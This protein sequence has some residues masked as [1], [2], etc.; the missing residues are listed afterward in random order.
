MRI[1]PLALALALASPLALGCKGG[2]GGESA[3]DSTTSGADTSTSAGDTES[4][5]DLPSCGDG[6]SICITPLRSV[7]V[8]FVIDNS[9]S[10]AEEQALLAANFASFIEILESPKV[11]ADYRIG[12]TTTD[13]G[14]PMCPGSATTPEGGQLVLSSCV[15]RIPLGEFV[16]TGTDPVTDA[17]FACTESCSKGDAELAIQPSFTSADGVEK[18][19]P[20]IERIA[21][22]TNLPAGVSMTEA[23]QCF[24]PQ[25]VA[26]CGFESPLESLDRAL[27]RM[28]SGGEASYGFLRD[29]ALLAVIFLTDEV[30]CSYNPAHSEIFTDNKVFWNDPGDLYPTSAACWRAGVACAGPGPDYPECW[31]ES[32]DVGGSPGA[33]DDD[34]VLWPLG[35]YVDRLQAIEDEKRL[36]NVEAEVIVSVIAG[37]PS[38]YPQNPQV[39]SEGGDAQFLSDFGIGPGCV[40]ASGGAAVPPVRLR[41]FAE[42]FQVGD[43]TNLFSICDDDYSPALAAIA[44]ILS[45]NL[46]PTCILDCVADTDP[47]TPLLD[48][49]CTI[50]NTD[51]ETKV[52][53]VVPPCVDEGGEWTPPPGEPACHVILV[54]PGGVTPT[55]D[56]DLSPICADNG[57]NAEIVVIRADPKV[58]LNL[59]YS[60][61]LS[62]DPAADCPGL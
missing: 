24:G 39:F 26:G 13:S 23:F 42:A 22:Q 5:G 27:A 55:I 60:C 45:A 62:A 30:D 57:W 19:R 32:H 48:P 25:G 54:D 18:A 6:D 29:E 56:D 14:N 4:G 38:G 11:R 52:P 36:I 41:E 53:S 16:F 15:D 51:L 28:E 35:R 37:V 40:S 9:G 7:D 47:Q 44:E 46:R 8:L 50:V 10:M 2:G 49:D 12:I 20:W 59:T 21:G 3:T 58:K 34:A 17:S 61:K 43:D 31:S 1:A 33:S